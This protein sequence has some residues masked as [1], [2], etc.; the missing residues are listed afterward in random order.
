[1]VR[2]APDAGPGTSGTLRLDSVGSLL[3]C[4]VKGSDGSRLH[5]AFAL[6]A[7]TAG[8]LQAMLA[9]LEIRQAA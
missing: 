1:M 9:R 7:A 3:P 6:D 4:S 2:G 8:S 5:L